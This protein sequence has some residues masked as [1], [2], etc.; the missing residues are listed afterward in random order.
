M[1]GLETILA[2]ATG[3]V[4]PALAWLWF[5]RREDSKHPEP[6]RL[7]ALAFLGGMIAVAIVIP[8]Q[9]AIEP[10]IPDQ[11]L[12]FTAWSAIEEVT[13]YLV[14][15][16]TVLWRREDDEPI[17]AVIYMV[18]VAL[19]FAAVEN[20]LF[21]MNPDLAGGT[22]AMLV[23]TADLRAVGATL[24]HVFSSALIGVAL[25]AS[26]YKPLRTKAVYAVS[27]VI[28]AIV[29]HST[30]NFLI[31]NTPPEQVTR[32]FSFVWLGVVGLLAVL[33]WVKRIRPA[34]R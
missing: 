20:T 33:E 19:G 21:L 4:L 3:G 22:L 29:L 26:F 31:L 5:W 30:F 9:Q 10:Y 32:T 2:A 11:T 17:D 6:R 12:L 15:L 13:K 16:A 7:I 1:S 8:L 23:Q 25:A 28:L 24:L 14:A 18:T 34:S 27:G